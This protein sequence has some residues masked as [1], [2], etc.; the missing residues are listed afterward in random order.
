MEQSYITLVVQYILDFLKS[1]HNKQENKAT[2][3]HGYCYLTHSWV[4]EEK[5]NHTSFNGI[6]V[7]V[8]AMSRI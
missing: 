2:K 7:K 1:F 4:W 8:N 3:M 6:Y 5:W